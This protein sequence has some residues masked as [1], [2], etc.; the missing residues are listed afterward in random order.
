MSEENNQQ[1]GEK[2][3][4]ILPIECTV[5]YEECEKKEDNTK[6][7]SLA[8]TNEKL[9]F[10]DANKSESSPIKQSNDQVVILDIKEDD[11]D[12]KGK[13]Y[14]TI[15]QAFEITFGLTTETE[16]D[17]YFSS[18]ETE[19]IEQQIKE[20]TQ[21]KVKCKVRKFTDIGDKA[22]GWLKKRRRN[23]EDEY[24]FAECFFI[25][26]PK[27]GKYGRKKFCLANKDSDE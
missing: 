17:N 16:E 4:V 3:C 20:K 19:W 7:A 8:Q 25:L 6:N 22:W 13:D 18:D 9:N 15:E 26:E 24:N 2:N 5:K 11:Y 21:K 1:V 12:E 23:A 27:R 14:C 10:G